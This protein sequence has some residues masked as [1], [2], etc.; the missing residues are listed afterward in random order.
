MRLLVFSDIHQDKRACEDLVRRSARADLV[1]GAGDFATRHDG[2]EETIAALGAIDA[3]SVVAPGNNETPEALAAA[4][5]AGWP[6][7]H[8]LHGRVATIEGWRVLGIG[9]GVPPTG[10]EWSFDLDEEEVEDL[11]G[12]LEV[13]LEATGV[14]G[15]RIDALVTHSPPRGCCDEV[16]RGVPM[17]SVAIAEAVRRLR[18]RVVVCGHV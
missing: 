2:L 6:R 4:C 3:P 9:A 18:P 7:A 17:G 8:V 12:A 11:V 5:A 15:R 13:D 14:E 10:K 1:V 16:A